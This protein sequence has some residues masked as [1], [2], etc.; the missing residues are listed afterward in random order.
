MIIVNPMW[1]G[2]VT[3]SPHVIWKVSLYPSEVTSINS[4]KQPCSFMFKKKKERSSLLLKKYAHVFE[5]FHCSSIQKLFTIYWVNQ[6][7][8]KPLDANVD[9][10]Q[11]WQVFGACFGRSAFLKIVTRKSTTLQSLTSGHPLL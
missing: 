8:K 3:L 11:R 4:R 2:H 1:F 7:K 5:I 9:L 10:Q 6:K